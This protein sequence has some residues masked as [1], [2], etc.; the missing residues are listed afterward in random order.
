VNIVNISHSNLERSFRSNG[1]AKNALFFL[2]K[3]ICFVRF[4]NLELKSKNVK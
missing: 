4:N 3:F 1:K 2:L